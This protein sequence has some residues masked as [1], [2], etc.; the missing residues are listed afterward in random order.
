M[1]LLVAALIGLSIGSF[2]NVVIYRLPRSI[3]LLHPPS[4]CPK[5]GHRLAWY[6]LVPVFSF[7]LYRGRCRYC[8]ESISWQYPFIEALTATLFAAIAVKF[9]SP[10][11][12]VRHWVFASLLIA[13]SVIDLHEH[14]I[15]NRLSIPGVT[16]GLV[17]SLFTPEPGIVDAAVGML[18]CGGLMLLLALLSNGGMGGGDIKLMAMIG[19]YLGWKAGL[20]GLF[21]GSAIG[22]IVSLGLIASGRMGRKDPIPF[23]PFLS[24]GAMLMV[25]AGEPILRSLGW[26]F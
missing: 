20:I 9:G 8:H 7:L 25:F 12:V 6:D 4:T 5:C 23:G 24:A 2:L 26:V 16:V 1:R 13:I 17:F 10:L 22:L 3:S 15:P 11:E 14:I 21:L 19:S 18:I